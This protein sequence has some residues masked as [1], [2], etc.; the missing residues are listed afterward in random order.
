MVWVLVGGVRLLRPVVWFGVSSPGR[1]IEVD[2]GWVAPPTVNSE[3]QRA[4]VSRFS[5]M[6][7]VEKKSLAELRLEPRLARPPHPHT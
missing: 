3:L 4:A 5:A 7:L 6:V 2:A 1:S